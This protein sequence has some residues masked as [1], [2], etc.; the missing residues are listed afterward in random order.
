[1]E[2]WR[3]GRWCHISLA[4]VGDGNQWHIVMFLPVV[5]AISWT[6]WLVLIARGI[7]LDEI[8]RDPS[9]AVAGFAPAVVP[10]FVAVFLRVMDPSATPFL[11]SRRSIRSLLLGD[12]GVVSF[13]E[14]GAGMAAPFLAAAAG[15]LLANVFFHFDIPLDLSSSL[16]PALLVPW[17]AALGEEFG[18]RGVLLAGGPSPPSLRKA[19]EVG[20]VWSLWYLPPWYLGTR[21]GSFSDCIITIVASTLSLLGVSIIMTRQ[22]HVSGR[23]ML[24]PILAHWATTASAIVLLPDTSRYPFASSVTGLFSG[25]SC[26]VFALTYWHWYPIDNVDA[27]DD[28]KS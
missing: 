10:S 13:E 15:R 14:V 24:V 27:S 25:A 9:L 5:F 7:S 2:L 18:W 11:T 22:W 26:L 8:M 6:P 20:L 16:L 17:V 1:M 23:A 3:D 21:R 28:R 19:F 12:R 4:V